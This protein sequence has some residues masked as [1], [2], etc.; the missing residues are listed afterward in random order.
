VRPMDRI[1][2]YRLS[3]GATLPGVGTL[4]SAWRSSVTAAIGDTEGIIIDLRSGTY[5]ALGPLPA[6]ARHRAITVRVL[7]ESD[8]RRTIVS[9]L[10]KATKG[11][12]VR[13]LLESD[14]QVASPADLLDALH[15]WGYT[16]EVATA[17][18]GAHA[19]AIDVVVRDL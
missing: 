5:T 1:P 2:A 18:A 12:L 11:R 16:A 9:H 7:Q 8:G 15:H 10:N 17:K 13:S 4:S 3:G 6:T 14:E 19:T